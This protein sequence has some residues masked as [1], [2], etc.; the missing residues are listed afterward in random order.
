MAARFWV[1]QSGGG[2]YSSTD[3]ALTT[4]G[5]TG[6]VAPTNADDVHFDGAGTFGNTAC[7]I[8]ATAAALTVIFTSGYT[9]TL[10]INSNI[11]W[12]VSGA[13]TDNT[14]HAYSLLG[15]QN[16]GQLT[17]NA[18]ATITSGGKTFPG[19]VTFSVSSTKTLSGDWTITGTLTL[20]TTTQTINKT[21]AEVLSCAGLTATG[22]ATGTGNITLTGGTWSGSGVIT[23][24]GTL[25]FAGSSTVSGGVAFN[26]GT[27]KYTSGTITQSSSTLTVGGNTTFDTNGITW[28]TIS[29][30]A[31]ST[32][33]INSLLSAVTITHSGSTNPIYAGTAGFS[34]GTFIA[35][36][37]ATTNTITLKNSVTYTFTAELRARAS[38]LAGILTF[39]SDDGTL[40]AVMTLNNGAI[41][42]VLASFTRIDASNG[43]AIYTFNGTVTTCNNIFAFNDA[44]PPAVGRVVGAAFSGM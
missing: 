30:T 29:F 24:S 9:A 44:L 17:I 2:N 18:T 31:S 10:T 35:N 20:L 14:A 6:Q 32:Y 12:T 5:T 36:Q 42:N 39:T 40:K 15:T 16:A 43:R 8:T 38:N 11:T 4:G 28:N 26:T 25:S 7:T 41:C 27:L 37:A 33:T 23:I 22:N 1:G 19:N 13:F 3:W 34:V 21:T